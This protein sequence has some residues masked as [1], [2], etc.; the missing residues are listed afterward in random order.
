[1]KYIGINNK[2]HDL[3]EDIVRI[4]ETANKREKSGEIKKEELEILQHLMCIESCSFD[5]EW[6]EV[7]I[8]LNH[9][10]IIE[11]VYLKNE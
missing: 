8:L 1:M 10:N 11:T 2:I 6:Y 9:E 5:E 3:D 4:L 7:Y